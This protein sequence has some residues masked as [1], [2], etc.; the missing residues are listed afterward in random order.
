[1]ITGTRV[2]VTIVLGSLAGGMKVEEVAR[3]YDLTAEDVSAALS[4][5]AGLVDEEQHHALP[6]R[7]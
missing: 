3:E 7:S 5:A 4:Y 2:P 1:M 6:G